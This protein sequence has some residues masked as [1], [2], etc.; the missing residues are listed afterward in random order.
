MKICRSRILLGIDQIVECSL[1]ISASPKHQHH[2]VHSQVRRGRTRLKF[3]A[4]ERMDVASQGDQ[5]AL[6][7][8]GCDP[9]Q[10][11]SGPHS[12]ARNRRDQNKNAEQAMRNNFTHLDEGYPKLTT[13]AEIL[14]V[15]T[16]A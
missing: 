2:A 4:R 7:D 14:P 5:I 9:L 13:F 10:S 16:I 11:R 12:E 6:V 3:L 15:K 1:R 8:T